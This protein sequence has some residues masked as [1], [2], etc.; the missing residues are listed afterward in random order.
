[1][2]FR[3]GLY[4]S[5]ANN[6]LSTNHTFRLKNLTFENIEKKVEQNLNDLEALLK[7]SHVNEYKVF[8]LGNSFI[9]FLSHENFLPWSLKF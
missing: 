3:F 4:C 8:R 1:M 7:L 5:N 9:P 2:D 6:S